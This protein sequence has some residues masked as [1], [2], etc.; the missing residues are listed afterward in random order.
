MLLRGQ[1]SLSPSVRSRSR[2]GSMLKFAAQ[3]RTESECFQYAV[4]GHWH[5]MECINIG[6]SAFWAVTEDLPACLGRC[7]CPADRLLQ[8]NPPCNFKH[9][10]ANRPYMHRGSGCCVLHLL[11]CVSEGKWPAADHHCCKHDHVCQVPCASWPLEFNLILVHTTARLKR[12]VP[13]SAVGYLGRKRAL[14]SCSRQPWQPFRL[15]HHHGCTDASDIGV[16][17]VISGCK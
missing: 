12:H 11:S 17:N 5:S 9:D 15:Q 16:R 13:S 6:F 10:D 1:T 3:Q 7:S 14:F 4:L 8:S 2:A